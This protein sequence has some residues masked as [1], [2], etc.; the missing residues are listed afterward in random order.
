MKSTESIEDLKKVKQWVCWDTRVGRK[1][2]ICTYGGPASSTK[3]STWASYKDAVESSNVN[4][5]DGVGFVFSESDHYCGVDIDDCIDDSGSITEDAQSIIDQLGSY[6]EISPSGR[7]VK[8]F[9]K[10]DKQYKGRNENGLEYYT[11]GRFFTY[12][13]DCISESDELAD[14]SEWFA[15]KHKYVEDVELVTD[16]TEQ[17]YDE[18]RLSRAR[19]YLG[20][21]TPSIEGQ[22]GDQALYMAAIRLVQDFQLNASDAV[23]LLSQDFNPRCEPQWSI[24]DIEYK[25][26]CAMK[27]R[28]AD[29]LGKGNQEGVRVTATEADEFSAG[30]LINRKQEC[31]PDRLTWLP[32]NSPMQSMFDYIMS[33]NARENR[34]LAFSGALA[35]YC[36]LIGGKVMDESGVTSNLYTITLAPSSGGKQAPQ[37]AIRAVTDASSNGEWLGGKVTSDSAIGSILQKSPNAFC[38]WDEVGLFLQ[39]SKSG[40]QSTIT[41]LLLDLWG[42]TNSRFRLKQ[43]ADGDRDIVIDKPCFGFAGWSTAEHFWAGLNRMHLHDGFAGRL[44]VINT[45]ERAPRKRKVYQEA[46]SSL[47]SVSNFWT[48]QGSV[49]HEVGLARKPRKIMKVTDEAEEVFDSLWDKVEEFTDNDEQAV[50]G[51]A[52][53][54]ARKIA[55]AFA[56]CEGPDA[57]INGEHA[58]RACELVDYITE[59]FMKEARM[60]LM[61][62]ESEQEVRRDILAELKRGNGVSYHGSL[63]RAVNTNSTTFDKALRTMEDNGQVKMIHEGGGRRKVVYCG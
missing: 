17:R 23:T 24:P 10:C 32:A 56:A 27:N 9:G 44:F 2:P 3:R 4:G 13:G 54:K 63:L 39:K 5:Y 12:T 18:E 34:S 42:A 6:T 28:R 19:A 20:K 26:N 22:G 41:D 33:T 55:L 15:D 30:L 1:M 29:L 61:G 53:E 45:G 51:R 46:P 60:K 11:S 35:W 21:M 25:V 14:L 49:L 57:K 58:K 50:W 7:G 48:E 47:V 37:D 62:G 40:V 52:P 8:I 59:A 16:T 43:Y 38:L 31:L 36:A